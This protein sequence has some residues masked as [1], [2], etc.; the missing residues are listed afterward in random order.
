MADFAEAR[1]E[2]ANVRAASE[3]AGKTAQAGAERV[4]ALDRLA[5][6]RAAA[7]APP[8]K[9]T[10]AFEDSLFAKRFARPIEPADAVAPAHE[11]FF[12]LLGEL[13][14]P[15]RAGEVVHLASCISALLR[16]VI[17]KRELPLM[18]GKNVWM[19]F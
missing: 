13:R 9:P 12:S 19:R 15:V 2:R 14:V 8:A 10:P 6:E 18:N 7:A 11:Q 1:E 16:M 17:L 5:E 3:A 4:A